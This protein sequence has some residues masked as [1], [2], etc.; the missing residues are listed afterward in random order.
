MNTNSSINMLD[1]LFILKGLGITL[2]LCLCS[3]VLGSALGIFIGVMRTSRIKVVSY[4]SWVYIYIVRGTPLLMQLFLVYY[5]LPI[6]MGYS[7]SAFATATMGLTL[8]AAAYLAEIVK[9]G[10]Q[11]VDS[12]QKEA[13]KALGMTSLQE[14][15]YI[16]FPQALKVIIPPSAGFFI[17]LIKDS[18]L[19]SAIGFMEL[20][21]S[22]KLVI[23]RTF[24][25]FT[26][27]LIVALMYFIICYGLSKFSTYVEG[28]LNVD[29]EKQ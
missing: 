4:L 19:V 27:Y 23:A 2:I 14:F 5:G 26:I 17:A 21:R 20:T 15:R 24:Q 25:P 13:A 18:S 8:Y 3:M 29:L 16:V 28:G 11:S 7:I 9:A 12:G 22:S 6:L 10:I 1:C